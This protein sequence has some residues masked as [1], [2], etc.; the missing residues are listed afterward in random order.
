MSETVN[1]SP[2]GRLSNNLLYGFKAA[3]CRSPRAARLPAGPALLSP[4][5]SG[6]AS[7]GRAATASTLVADRA[8]SWLGPVGSDG[9]RQPPWGEPRRSGPTS[10]TCGQA[11]SQPDPRASV[12]A[13]IS[14]PKAAPAQS[15]STNLVTSASAA[16]LDKPVLEQAGAIYSSLIN[17]GRK[18]PMR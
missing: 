7:A 16:S 3:R 14:R 17:I 1:T 10:G 2:T 6:P 5:R 18:R 11:R 8:P 4:P 15:R 9:F 13:P 12:R